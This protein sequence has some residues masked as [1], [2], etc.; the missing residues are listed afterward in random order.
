[1][2]LH[3]DTV[4][5]TLFPH[6]WRPN[7]NWR[8]WILKIKRI[9]YLDTTRNECFLTLESGEAELVCFSDKELV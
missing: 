7:A 4:M 3:L 9:E 5:N 8:L 6:I 2:Y 1:M